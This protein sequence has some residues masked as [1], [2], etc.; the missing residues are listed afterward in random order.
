MNLLL[1]N[2]H[3]FFCILVVTIVRMKD[4]FTDWNATVIRIFGILQRSLKSDENISV[5]FWIIYFVTVHL[6]NCFT[7]KIPETRYTCNF[8]L[9]SKVILWLIC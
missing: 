2:L 5:I 3:Y 9:S 1:K 6:V 7:L 4:S 8:H